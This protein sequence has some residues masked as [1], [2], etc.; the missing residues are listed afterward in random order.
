MP[1]VNLVR[2][3]LF[4]ALGRTYTDKE[5][6]NLCF[7]FGIELDDVTSEREMYLRERG[8]LDTEEAKGLSAE[9]IYKIDIPA[10]R[11][12]LLCL[13]GIARALR[14]FQEIEKVPEYKVT[15]PNAA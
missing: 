5:F 10:N 9:V 15:T 13:E 2:D 14:I 6:Q 4:R 1:T 11:Y 8:V 7:S 12:D 3:E